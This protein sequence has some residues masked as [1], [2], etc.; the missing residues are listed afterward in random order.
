LKQS[1]QKLGELAEH[2]RKIAEVQ[3]NK[4]QALLESKNVFDFSFFSIF[5]FNI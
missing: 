4:Q 5:N 1:H 3:G 2:C